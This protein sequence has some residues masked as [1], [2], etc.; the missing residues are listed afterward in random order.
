MGAQ[1]TA[2]R[3]TIRDPYAREE[4]GRNYFDMERECLCGPETLVHYGDGDAVSITA[5]EIRIAFDE[6]R[7]G[8][9]IKHR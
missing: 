1:V 6:Y 5:E 9:F 7:N 8:T 3:G 4:V 2:H